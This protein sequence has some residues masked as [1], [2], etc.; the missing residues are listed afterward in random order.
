MCF[1]IVFTISIA[2][3]D[4][5]FLLYEIF[6]VNQRES[7]SSTVTN[8]CGLKLESIFKIVLFRINTFFIDTGIYESSFPIKH[9]N[10]SSHKVSI[11]IL[12][13]PEV[14]NIRWWK[15]NF[16]VKFCENDLVMRIRM[17]RW[18]YSYSVIKFGCEVNIRSMHEE[19]DPI[20]CEGS[21][22]T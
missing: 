4:I 5:V 12:V 8:S 1:V 7:L 3:I 13:V 2:F 17:Y 19:E 14:A 11:C 9:I 6:F 15:N 21:L 20:I 18:M 10:C 22:I 16:L